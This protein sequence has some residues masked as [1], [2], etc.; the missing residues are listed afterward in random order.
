MRTTNLLY[1]FLLL[2]L[3]L[4]SCVSENKKTAENDQDSFQPNKTVEKNS[5]YNF[6][7]EEITANYG[8]TTDGT[9]YIAEKLAK[10]AFG[11]DAVDSCGIVVSIT[12]AP[13]DKNSHSMRENFG[14][15]YIKMD[16]VGSYFIGKPKDDY[17]IGAFNFKV[18]YESDDFK[19]LP[20]YYPS[21]FKSDDI[22]ENQCGGLLLYIK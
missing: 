13:D 9:Y 6:Q 20:A 18:A 1:F 21:G 4:T 11:A 16:K 3:S 17:P 7:P 2:S 8:V 10:E 19:Y 22:Y 14:K 15:K 5:Q 12:N